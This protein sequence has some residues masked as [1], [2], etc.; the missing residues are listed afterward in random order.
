MRCFTHDN[1]SSFLL[2]ILPQLA[3]DTKDSI[4]EAGRNAGAAHAGLDLT[5]STQCD[6]MD[7]LV[8]QME[9]SCFY[10]YG[11]KDVYVD[12]A[13]AY[14]TGFNEGAEDEVKED[15]VGYCDLGTMWE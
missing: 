4:T 10:N 15:F 9:D 13:S 5:A 6:M 7:A 2:I 14:M 8:R 11:G 1:N 3:D 12:V